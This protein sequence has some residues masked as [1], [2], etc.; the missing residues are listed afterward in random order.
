MDYPKDVYDH[1]NEMLNE[2]TPTVKIGDM[3]YCA[4]T[5]LREVDPIAYN[6]GLADWLDSLASDGRFCYDCEVIGDC[7]CEEE[8]WTIQEE[9]KEDKVFTIK[10]LDGFYKKPLSLK[11]ENEE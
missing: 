9:G 2:V 5:V 6:V 10:V 8:V 4:S 1:Y 3:N 7:E 11:G